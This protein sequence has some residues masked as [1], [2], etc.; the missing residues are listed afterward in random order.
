MGLPAAE[1]SVWGGGREN[2]KVK[3]HGGGGGGN[4]WLGT[5]MPKCERDYTAS[6][7]G[8]EEE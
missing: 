7:Y 3:V 1:R 5:H 8:V 6:C 2:G 4:F